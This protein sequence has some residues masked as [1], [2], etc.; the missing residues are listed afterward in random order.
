MDRD[1]G[2]VPFWNLVANPIFRR[3]VRSRLRAKALIPWMLV[4]GI[5]VTFVFL[6][7]WVGGTKN[8][9]DTVVIG[10]TVLMVLVPIQAFLLML[11]GTGAVASGIMLEGADG[12]IEY[13]RLTPLAPLTKIVGYLFGLPIR[14]YCLV[15]VTLPFSVIG[16]ITGEVPLGLLFSLYAAL[17]TSAVLYHLSGCVA[18]MVVNRRFAGRIAQLMVIIL[19]LVLPQIA[20]LGFEFFSYLTVLPVLSEVMGELVPQARIFFDRVFGTGSR[21]VSLFGIEVEALPFS[22]LI[23]GTLIVTFV[24]ILYRKWRQPTHHMLG[25][26]FAACL[27][28][29]VHLLLLGSTIPLIDSGDIFPTELQGRFRRQA[30]LRAELARELGE[31]GPAVPRGLMVPDPGRSKQPMHAYW[32]SASY[33]VGSLLLSCGLVLIVTPS[34]DEF[35]KGLRR[36]R[37]LGRRRVPWNADGASALAHVLV[38]ALTGAVA[39]SIFCSEMYGSRWF[40][41]KLLGPRALHFSMPELRMVP[42]SQLLFVLAFWAVLE[43]GERRNLLLFVLFAWVVPVLAAMIFMIAGVNFHNIAIALGGVSAFPSPFYA[44]SFPLENPDLYLRKVSGTFVVVVFLYAVL[45]VALIRRVRRHHREI[46][47]RVEEADAPPPASREII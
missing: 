22:L 42:F 10:R 34:R 8:G 3:Y 7:V 30:Q 33:G 31:L 27:C 16:A 35:T 4:V 29:W 44:L 32:L 39:W 45:V 40:A 28:V 26:N 5:V 43:W 24:V 46:T 19:Y 20:K 6:A 11:V 15:L 2:A 38:I 37:K 13:Q 17:F 1:G 23:Q 12:G 41:E 18:G 9:F 25:K 21:T 36:K 14:E 47:R